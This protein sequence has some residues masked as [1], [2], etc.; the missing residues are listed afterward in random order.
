M[1]VVLTVDL[2]EYFFSWLVR[3]IRDHLVSP[4]YSSQNFRP[5]STIQNCRSFENHNILVRVWSK[6]QS[7]HQVRSLSDGVKMTRVTKII[8]PIK[9]ATVHFVLTGLSAPF[10]FVIL[11]R[12][13]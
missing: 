7:V 4:F 6:D 10:T 5:F 3:R 13:S 12:L 8:A 9:I 2:I 11:D 1:E